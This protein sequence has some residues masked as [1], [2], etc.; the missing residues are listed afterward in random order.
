MAQVKCFHCKAVW[1]LASATTNRC[2]TCGCIT[3]IFYNKKEAERVAKLY[4]KLQPPPPA[5]SGVSP[6][7]GIEGFSVPF[8]E[9][10]R[11]AEV[12]AQFIGVKAS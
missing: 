5:P 11:I 1:D 4:N 8:P 7:V 2:P 6:L 10:S 9:Q 3:E 12:A